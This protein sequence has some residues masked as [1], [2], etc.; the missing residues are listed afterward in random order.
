MKIK[1]SVII[2]VYNAEKTIERCLNSLL[3]QQREDA[4]II[5]IDDGSKD[6]SREIIQQYAENYTGI[7]FISQDNSGV[8]TTRNR[9]IEKARGTYILFV[10]SDDFVSKDY[11]SI[12]DR[13]GDQSDADLIMFS[14]NTIG[15]KTADEAELYRRLENSDALVEKIKLLLATRK[16]MSPWNKRF[17]KDI[18][19]KNNIRFVKEFQ[20]GEDFNFCLEYTLYCKTIKAIHKNI[21]NVDISDNNSLSRKYRKNLDAQIEKVFG[22]AADLIRKSTLRDHDKAILLEIVDYLF[23]KNIFTC[24][25]EEF[26]REK[27]SYRRRRGD[28]IRIYGRFEI[29]LCETG[30]Y[31]NLIHRVLRGLIKHRF[32][33]LVY[34]VTKIVKEKKFSEYLRS[35]T[36]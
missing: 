21:Y 11:F 26:K 22:N 14:Q 29:S 15:G 24:I 17:K 2:P 4:E 9:G 3:G 19:L 1:Y 20:T 7:I 23:V 5:V 36:S 18:I 28:I 16:I 35:S 6:R 31:Y 8:S 25:A 33:F 32:V 10:D 34:G 30:G 12:L 13:A 27:S